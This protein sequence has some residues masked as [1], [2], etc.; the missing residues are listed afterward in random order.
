MNEHEIR[1]FMEDEIRRL[2]EEVME[3]SL[4]AHDRLERARGAFYES[5]ASL[6]AKEAPRAMRNFIEAAQGADLM[7]TVMP[8]GDG[9]F[10]LRDRKREFN[11]SKAFGGL[12]ARDEGKRIYRRGSH[13]EIENDEQR[14]RRL[15]RF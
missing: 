10:G 1:Q 15:R 2:E 4:D 6:S 7:G 5:A 8:I 3:G 11:F 12:T 13:F 14:D 9:T